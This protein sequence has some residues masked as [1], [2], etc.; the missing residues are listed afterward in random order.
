M[1][2]VARLHRIVEEVVSMTKYSVEKIEKMRDYVINAL[3]ANYHYNYDTAKDMV[4]DSVFNK[5]LIED[6]DYV[7]HYTVSYWAKEVNNEYCML[8]V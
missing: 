4:F 5:L 3:V 6:T 7:F 8:C 1:F 2:S